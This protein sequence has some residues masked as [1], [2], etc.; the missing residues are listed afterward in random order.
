M[1]SIVATI[2]KAFTDPNDPQR[3]STTRTMGVMLILAGIVF[4]FMHHSDFEMAGVL[5]S[6]GFVCLGLRK[7]LTTDKQ[8]DVTT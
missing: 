6:S 3:M 2:I 1:D 7:K 8:T 4:S 5:L